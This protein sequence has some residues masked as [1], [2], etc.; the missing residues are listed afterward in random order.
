MRNQ[1]FLIPI[2]GF[3]LLFPVSCNTSRNNAE[4]KVEVLPEDIVELRD[5]QIKLAQIEQGSIEMRVLK[6]ILKVNG[7]VSMTPQNMASVCEPLGGF[8]RSASLMPG[9][10]VRKGEILAIIENQ[11]FVD[12][13]EQ[14]LESKSKLEYAE[15]EFKRHTDLF[16]E[17]VYS[18]K[19]LQQVTAEYKTLKTKVKAL[20][21]KLLLIGLN[22]VSLHEE[23]ITGAVAV[24]SPI[25]GF[26]SRININIGKYVAPTDVLFEIVNSDN[27]FLELTLF[28]KDA[29]QAEVGQ[30][31]GFF[32]NNEEDTH[33]AVIYQT[34]KSIGEDKTFKVYARVLS[35]CENV[36]PGMYVNALIEKPG[37]PS[38]SLPS[39]AIVSFDDQDYIFVFNRDK[40]ENDRLFTEF[41]MIPVSKGLID[42]SF[43]EVILPEGLDFSSLKVVVKGAYTL[44]SAKKN[45]GEMAC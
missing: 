42:G 44:L 36:L 38:A 33:E 22:P 7:I 11:D 18:E 24:K 27:L 41:K 15:A 6:S 34:G 28:D 14:Y 20:E 23:N 19:D 43:T 29:D 16:R 8:V 17:D 1:L 13:Q 2:L 26:V 32:I 9:Q 31:I 3:A 10:S 21:Q 40:T 35:T 25:N 12:I 39:E 5:D 4:T 30:K 37:K 45:A